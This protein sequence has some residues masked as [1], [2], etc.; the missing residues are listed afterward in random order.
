MWVPEVRLGTAIGAHVALPL[1]A[2][3]V[4]QVLPEIN[5]VEG[6]IALGEN[7]KAPWPGFCFARSSTSFNK[8]GKSSRA[9]SGS[10]TT[11]LREE[12]GS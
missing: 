9:R 10:K 8:R 12:K 11:S 1:G 3:E 4:A 6:R 7:I 5:R 2:G